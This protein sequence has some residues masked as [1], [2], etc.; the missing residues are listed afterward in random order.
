VL[1][2]LADHG[3]AASLGQLANALGMGPSKVHRYLVSLVRVGFVAQKTPNGEYDL[4]PGIRML[5]LIALARTDPYDVILDAAQKLRDETGYTVLVTVWGDAGVTII[6]WLGGMH[7]TSI[8]F[9]LGSTLPLRH[10]ATGRLFLAHL[11]ESK[12]AQVLA[13]EDSA[14]GSERNRRTLPAALAR[15]RKSGVSISA[16]EILPGVMA[17]SGP[18]FSAQSDLVAA[19]T[20]L[21]R[22]Q[23]DAATIGKLTRVLRGACTGISRGFG[24]PAG[25]DRGPARV[26]VG[27]REPPV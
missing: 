20:V 14:E 22:K 12:T 4:G 25:G 10:S 11:P 19:I 16:G 6:R 23:S 27:D 13:T 7:P 24:Y 15:I 3:A 5:G 8:A 9:R 18:I 1:Q 17:L 21:A 2:A 26:Y